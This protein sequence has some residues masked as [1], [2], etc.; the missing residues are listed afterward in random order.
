MIIDTHAHLYDEVYN[1]DISNVIIR[2]I[3]ENICNFFLPSLNIFSLKNII[4]I[5]TMYPEILFSMIGIHPN[6]I[7]IKNI[8]KEIDIMKKMVNKRPFIAIGEIGIDIFNSKSKENINL[9]KKIFKIQIEIAKEKNLPIV[10]HS[11]N[12]IDIVLD[13]LEKNYNS[14]SGVIHCF[15]GNID[16]AKRSIKIGLKLGIGGI[17]FY[18]KNLYKIIKKIDLNNIILETD[19]PYLS[20]VKGKRNE[21]FF[22]K[23]IIKE[24]SK[25]S[26]LPI[27]EIIKININNVLNTF[28]LYKP[29]FYI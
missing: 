28:N 20:P 16:Q 11:R 6:Y 14:I 7:N 3:K 18:N 29:L 19:C 4:H 22:L 13:I 10:I 15:T 25:I 2:A 12:S 26:S 24:I 21:P 17:L 27:N 23:K 1:I 8:Y 9:Q 5:E